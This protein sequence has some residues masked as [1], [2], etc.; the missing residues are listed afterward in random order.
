[1]LGEISLKQKSA[2]FAIFAP[3]SVWFFISITV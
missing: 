1:M 2:T 3:V